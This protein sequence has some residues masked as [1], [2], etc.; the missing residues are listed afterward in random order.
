M[1]NVASLL[2]HR[3]RKQIMSVFLISEP[4]CDHLSKAASQD[5][6]IGKVLFTFAGGI[7]CNYGEML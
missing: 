6:F 5:F 2:L 7:P 3:R 4:E 1:D